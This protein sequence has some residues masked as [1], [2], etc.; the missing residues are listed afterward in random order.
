MNS[1]NFYKRT[2]LEQIFSHK[3]DKND[4]NALAL[5]EFD[6]IHR[7]HRKLI[8][9]L[10]ARGAMVVIDKNRADITPKQRR[11]EFVPNSCFYY[12]F[13]S[14]K[15]LSSEEFVALLK[16]DFPNVKKIVIG[17]D[18]R[19][20]RNREGGIEE[21]EKLF[22]GKVVIVPEFC[23]DGISVHTTKIRAFLRSCEIFQANR[24]LGRE[25]ALVGF[26]QKG[27]GIGGK[28]LYPTVNLRVEEYLIPGFGVY[29]GRTKIKENIYDS[30]IFIGQRLSTDEKFSLETHILDIKVETKENEK[31]ELFFVDFIRQNRKFF[32]LD[33]LKMQIS[34]DIKNARESLKSCKIYPDQ[35]TKVI[36]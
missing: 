27:Q 7:A 35:L 14:I 23:Y 20:G 21:L 16:R 19:F 36:R 15:G 4:I 6:G 11:D 5:G 13:F 9:Q 32:K 18:F 33:D 17:Y 10:G 1:N 29:A 26:V 22:E 25:Y 34:E 8:E 31:C 3:L 2:I 28:E 12:D 30:V 24:L